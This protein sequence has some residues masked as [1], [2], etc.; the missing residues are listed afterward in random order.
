[1]FQVLSL[2]P[3]TSRSGATII[4]AM[5]LG[6]SRSV[7]AEFSFFLGHPIILGASLV[8]IVKYS[9]A[10]TLEEILYLVVGLLVAFLVSAYSVNFLIN[11]VKKHDFKLFGYY[12]IVL[13]IIVLVWFLVS[14]LL[15]VTTVPA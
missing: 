12:R 6:C 3:G 13:G 14:S 11:W 7:A 4:G 5:L 9:G 8:K 2:I 10:F 1:M 15:N